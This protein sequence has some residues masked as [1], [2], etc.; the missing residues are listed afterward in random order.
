MI[1]AI[2]YADLKFRNAQKFNKDTAIH[3]G[4]ADKVISY[5]PKDID[6]SFMSK[7][8][9]ILKQ[10]RGNGYWLW[11]PY[12]IERTL[13]EMCEGDYLIYL[14]SG[15]FYINDVRYL[16]QQMEKDGQDIMAFELPFKEKR[17]TKRDVFVA[18]EC[19]E[20]VYTDTNQRM[21]T[22]IILRKSRQSVQ[23]VKEWLY[24]CQYQDIITDVPN[25]LGRDNYKEFIDHRHDQSIFSVLSKKYGIKAYRDPSQ[26]GRLPEML[27]GDKIDRLTSVSIYP[28][29]IAAHKEYT[30][31]R[32]IFWE[33]MIYAYAPARIVKIYHEGISGRTQ[34]KKK[35][36]VLTDN[37]P[38]R[39]DVYGFGMYKVVNRLLKALGS[40]VDTVIVTDKSYDSSKTDSVL[41]GKIIA[42]NIFH[43]VDEHRF[44]DVCFLLEIGHLICDL[45]KKGIRDIFIPLGADYKELRRAYLVS[46]VYHMRVSIYVVDDFIEYQRK[47][48]GSTEGL[49]LDKR[50]V[51]Y[52][53]EVNR[54]FV[55]SKGMK[56]RIDGLTGRK[57]ILLPLPYEYREK[58][59]EDNT[60]QNQVMFIGQINELYIYGIKDIAE[61]IDKVNQD[62]GADIKLLFTYK[63]AAEVKRLVGNYKC[64][65]SRRI[66]EEGELRK[67][68]KN[69]MFCIM[70]YSDVD[71]L[72]LLQNTS[73]PSKLI[74]YMSS[75]RLIVVYGNDKNSAQQYFDEN[76]LPWVMHGRDKDLLEDYIAALSERQ[77]D[78][79]R[80][81]TDILRKKHSFKYI[82]E[83][84]MR[85][86]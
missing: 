26:F 30:V 63:N 3:K 38:I 37:M 67:E 69:S 72:S 78:Y 79:S 17:Y 29:I 6:S 54:I 65:C 59:T 62:K 64:I 23:F 45:R 74:E 16:T 20:T 68:I 83:K 34:T 15:V 25:H 61:I 56:D 21:A 33:Q 13:E 27:W 85:Y 28:Q 66:K 14:D 7:N 44:S 41:E 11:K 31:N 82:R 47:I 52:L 51:R 84:L 42:A 49:Q 55:I 10:K 5:S 58:D 76:G 86:M 18:L 70:P 36:A 71:E 75:A 73:F 46:K 77:E 53:K 19:D 32:N 2:N 8:A 60:K 9:N 35:I 81:Y 50:I 57:T 80:D 39:E 24:F 43:K 1:V 40:N 4:K 48:I 22:M 12:F